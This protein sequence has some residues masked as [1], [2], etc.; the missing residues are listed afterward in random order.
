MSEIFPLKSSMSPKSHR[1]LKS[2]TIKRQKGWRNSRRSK[3]VFGS[4]N[5][6]TEG[7]SKEERE[8]IDKSSQ[9]KK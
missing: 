5:S 2:S 8:Y 1:E 3:A 9:G 6:I 7:R 4:Q